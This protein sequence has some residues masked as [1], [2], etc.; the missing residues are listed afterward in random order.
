MR[1]G[2][3]PASQCEWGNV[4]ELGD[5]RG[6][7]IGLSPTRRTSGLSHG[8]PDLG[9]IRGISYGEKSKKNLDFVVEV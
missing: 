2:G 1:V 8:F 7:W 3:V 4:L 9:P 5:R 6:V